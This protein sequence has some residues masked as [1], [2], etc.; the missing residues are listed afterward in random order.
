M[1]QTFMAATIRKIID[2][3]NISVKLKTDNFYINFSAGIIK[4]FLTW[5]KFSPGLTLELL[6]TLILKLLLTAAA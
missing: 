4:F 3:I 5:G 6:Q 1:A 2:F